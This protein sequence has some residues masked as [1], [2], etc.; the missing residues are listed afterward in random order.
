MEENAKQAKTMKSQFRQNLWHA[1]QN[2]YSMKSF[3]LLLVPFHLFSF[4]LFS[5]CLTTVGYTRV[6]KVYD[7]LIFYLVYSSTDSYIVSAA[8][9]SKEKT[10]IA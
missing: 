3:S 5:L 4:Y 6:H 10:E 7:K 8:G 2:H 1:I 9:E